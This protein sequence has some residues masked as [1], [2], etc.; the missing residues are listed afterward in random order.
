MYFVYIFSGGFAEQMLKLQRR[1]RSDR[2]IWDHK[3]NELKK[4]G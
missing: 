2:V 4:K 1:E 3:M